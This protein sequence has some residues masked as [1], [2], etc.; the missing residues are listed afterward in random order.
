HASL[1]QRDVV[2]TDDARDLP[3]AILLLPE[4]NELRLADWLPLFRPR[5]METMNAYLNGTIAAHRIHLKRPCN[6]L[7]AHLA[8]DVLLNTFGQLLPAEG[9]SALI[10]IKLHIVYEERPELIQI[11]LVVGVEQCAVERR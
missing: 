8:A 6:E 11:A 10:V 1:R 9:Q 5:M 7:P 2:V 3:C 4:V